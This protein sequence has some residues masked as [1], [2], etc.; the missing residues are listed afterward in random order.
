MPKRRP[1]KYEINSCE[2]DPTEIVETISQAHAK[3]L[4]LA[5][6]TL[7][8]SPPKIDRPKDD[9]KNPAGEEIEEVES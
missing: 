6:A 4:S 3:A 5:A 9:A 8:Y 7:A 1:D 2:V